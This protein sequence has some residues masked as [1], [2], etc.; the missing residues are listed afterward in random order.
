[1]SGERNPYKAHKIGVLQKD[2]WV[3]MI[4]VDGDHI[5]DIKIIEYHANNLKLIVNNGNIIKNVI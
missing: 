4:L 2:A 3:D 1:M 5:E